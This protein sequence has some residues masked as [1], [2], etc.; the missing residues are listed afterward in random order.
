MIEGVVSRRKAVMRMWRSACLVALV[1]TG[2]LAGC[3]N[4]GST[5]DR[6]GAMPSGAGEPVASS[7]G[8]RACIKDWGGPGTLVERPGEGFSG[9][10]AHDSFDVAYPNGTTFS[11][12]VQTTRDAAQRLQA[13]TQGVLVATELVNESVSDEAPAEMKDAAAE[14]VHRVGNVVIM[15]SDPRHGDDAGVLRCLTTAR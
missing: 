12:A 8:L 3:G 7:G 2:S 4:G 6:D 11:V 5:A 15:Y 14:T 13:E 9:L 10:Q 1:S